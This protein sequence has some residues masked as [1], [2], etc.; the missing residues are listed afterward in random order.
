[1]VGPR[2]VTKICMYTRR[3]RIDG[4]LPTEERVISSS[5]QTITEFY[6][7]E[8]DLVQLHYFTKSICQN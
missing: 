4:S 2:F 6:S 5:V 8:T 1:M 3:A 7:T